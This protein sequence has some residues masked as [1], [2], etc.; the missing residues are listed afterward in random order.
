MK[1][2]ELDYIYDTPEVISLCLN[3][4]KRECTNCLGVNVIAK[5]DESAGATIDH[6][7][8]MDVYNRDYTDDRMAKELGVSVAV[9]RRYRKDNNI[10]TK[11][12]KNVLDATKLIAMYEQGLNDCQ[13]AK[14]LHLTPGYVCTVRNKLGLPSKH[15]KKGRKTD[16]EGI[17]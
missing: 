8:F 10:P 17:Q 15:Y 2:H 12:P 11:R 7:K 9:L 13:I 3:C 1:D 5:K 16:A 4:S 6:K 14:E